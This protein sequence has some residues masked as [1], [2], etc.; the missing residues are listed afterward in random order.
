MHRWYE[1]VKRAGLDYGDHFRT[2]EKMRTTSSGIKGESTGILRNVS[3][4][5]GENYHV[6][7]TVVDTCFQLLGAAANHGTTHN[8]RQ[9][10]PLSVEYMGISR[11]SNG[12][13]EVHA[14]CEPSGDGIVGQVTSTTDSGV[15]V[16]ILGAHMT[17]LDTSDDRAGKNNTPITARLEWVPD[18]NFANVSVLLGPVPDHTEYMPLLESLA[19]SA[20][21]L[22]KRALAVVEGSNPMPHVH[23]Y[24]DW[25]LQRVSPSLDE[26]DTSELTDS[27]TSL[28]ASLENTSAAQAATAI[29]KICNSIGP[30]ISGE[31]SGRH[32]LDADDLLPKLQRFTGECNISSFLR[33]LAQSKP[34]L[35]ILE[36]GAGLGPMSNGTWDDLRRPNGQAMY[37]KYVY[38]EAIPAL[39]TAAKERFGKTISNLEFATLD[40]RNDPDEQSFTDRDFDIVI[41]NGVVH[42]TA[43]IRTSLG[44]V[45][46][47]LRPGGW[48]LMQQPREGLTWTKYVFGTLPE[49]WCGVDDGRP[50]EPYIRPSR[51][52]D[53]LVATGFHGVRDPIDSPRPSHLGSVIVA[54]SYRETSSSK[55]VTILHR[56]GETAGANILST[57]LDA[58]GFEVTSCTLEDPLPETTSDVISLLDFTAPFLENIDSHSFGKLKSMLERLASSGSGIFWLTRPSQA[59][60]SNPSYAPIVGFARTVRSEMGIDFATCETDELCSPELTLEHASSVF[61]KFHERDTDSVLDPDME[62]LI[63]EGITYVSRSFPFSLEEDKSFQVASQEGTLSIGTPGRIES[64]CWASIR[65]RAPEGDEVEVEIHATGL[66]F[67]VS[68]SYNVVQKQVDV[69]IYTVEDVLTA[70]AVVE[71]RSRNPTLGCEAAG[72]VRRVGP[73]AKK[74]RIGDRVVLLGMQTFSTVLNIS[75]LLCEKLPADISFVEGASMPVVFATAI[76]SLI[77]VARLEKDQASRTIM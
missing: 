10:I 69:L 64:L 42:M 56:D 20:A 65:A 51:W 31:T 16:S 38:V 3:H 34:N 67:R 53:E 76:Q 40:I 55:R 43:S 66:N 46:K 1:R 23:K 29:I 60:N 71:L 19:Q 44:H 39:T 36:L 57:H 27:V 74:F 5:D 72:V 6:H 11:G 59:H 18:I 33:C 21:I 61:G 75:E 32:I 48:L 73:S 54:R 2:V 14:T 47:L 68:L 26:M 70:M 17:P 50:D 9:V 12:P 24:K 7:P 13:F 4:E 49:W 28:A 45:N 22:S 58:S 63:T 41:A 15:S 35:R 25:L 77:N 52:S 37:S 62:Y 8:Y 30:I